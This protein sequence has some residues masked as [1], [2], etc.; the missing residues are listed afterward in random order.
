MSKLKP[1]KKPMPKKVLSPASASKIRAK[2][3][4]ILSGA[5]GAGSAY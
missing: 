2:A 4:K 3:N 1:M 5:D